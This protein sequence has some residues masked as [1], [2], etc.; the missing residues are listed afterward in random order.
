M[1]PTDLQTQY[2]LLNTLDYLNHQL[3]NLVSGR[4]AAAPVD[5]NYAIA[6]DGATLIQG[7][8]IDYKEHKH[9]YLYS[10]TAFTL[11]L[12]E[13][14]TLSIAAKTWIELPLREGLWLYPTATLAATLIVVR[15]TNESISGATS[16]SALRPSTTSTPSSVASSA[17]DTLILAAN[18]GRLGATFYNDSTQNLFLLL[19]TGTASSSV[20]SVQLGAQDYFEL[21]G[22]CLYTG[23]VHGVWAAA[24]GNVRITEFT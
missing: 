10:P 1:K 14:G 6:N 19:A 11:N 15:A 22:P 18:N 3:D 21:P 9:L 2:Y 23:A 12:N 17:T 8:P 20:Y 4:H 16:A 7:F 24:N 5:T 13:L